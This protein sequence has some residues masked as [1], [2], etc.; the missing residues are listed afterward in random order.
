MLKRAT[1]L[2]A[3]STMGFPM[4]ARAAKT[5]LTYGGSGWLGHYSA[6][7]ALKT[8]LFDKQGLDIVWQSFATS[9]DRMGAVMAGNIDLAGTG[10]VSSLA[11]MAAGARQFQVI[12]TPNNFGRAEG[13][14]VREDV[15]DVAGLKGKKIGVTYAS[16]AHV[17]LLDVLQQAGLNPDKDVTI[18][19]L[20]ATNLLAAFQ[21]KQIEAAVVAWTPAFDR[22]KAIPGT[23]VLLDDT[24]FSLYKQYGITPGPD[25]LLTR[26]SIGKENPEAVH[27]FLTAVFQ[28]NTMMTESPAE[29]AK[30]LLELT[31]LSQQEQEAVITQTTWYT[32]KEQ[33]ALMVDPGNFVNGMQQLAGMLVSLKQ[34]DKAP[35]V[36]DWVQ[37]KYL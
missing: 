21:G 28:A 24:A 25:V 33:H 23:R 13:V 27:K 1:A 32:E 10:V 30:V 35:T 19:N 15:N 34:I 11:L 26:A 22:I 37:T 14:L 18:I 29:A 12:A 2:A 8:G 5:R 17:L 3:A 7:I 6:Y 36:K 9:S 4:I 31:G 16:S 20:P